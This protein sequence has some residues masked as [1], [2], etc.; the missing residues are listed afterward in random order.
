MRRGIV[1]VVVL[2]LVLC[3]LASGLGG[4]AY[5]LYVPTAEARPLV[6]ISSPRHGER[7][8]VGEPVTVQ[9]LARDEAE[10]V[11][12][13]ELWVDG[14]LLEAQRTAASGGISPFPLL[15]DWQ[16]LSP[17]AHTLI[18][19]AFNTQGAR[20]QGSVNVEAM[21]LPDRDGDEVPDD[22]DA[23]PDEAGLPEAD[24]CPV[25]SEGDRDGDGLLDDADACPDEPGSPL[26]GGC[27]D[28]DGDEV[29]D[30]ED[31]CPDEPG[32]PES[33]GCPTP[34]DLDDDGV[35]DEEDD[36]PQEWGMPEHSGCPD[37]DG[38]GLRDVDD[39]CPDE[40]G[41]L[42]Q[43]GCPD[44]DSDGVPDSDDLRP[45][46]PGRV[47][48]HGA[49]DSGAP[50]S[51]G[52]GL[53]DDIDECD[54]EE[55]L[56]EHAGCPP[57]GDGD[58][59]DDELLRLSPWENLEPFG[60]GFFEPW[61][62]PGVD[63]VII[64]TPVE[65]EALEFEV[66]QDYTEIYCYVGLTGEQPERYG[67]FGRIGPTRWD[68]AEVLGGENSRHFAVRIDEPLELQMECMGYAGGEPPFHLGLLNVEHPRD[69]W[70]GEVFTAWTEGEPGGPPREHRFVVMYRICADSC[71][72]AGLPPPILWPPQGL[73][74]H[75][76]WDWRGVWDSI[77]GFKLYVN[78]SHVGNF[79]RGSPGSLHGYDLPDS[80][81]PACGEWL[82]FEVT[83]FRGNPFDPDQESPPSNTVVLEGQPCP[84]RARVTF[85]D[86]Q[87]LNWP[88]DPPSQH[89]DSCWEEDLG[90]IDLRFVVSHGVDIQ[91]FGISTV[92]GRSPLC[93][94]S[95][96]CNR[97]QGYCLHPYTT[98]S[99]E[100]IV[101]HCRATRDGLSSRRAEQL[102]CPENFVEVTLGPRDELYV[103]ASI[104]DADTDGTWQRVITG[105]LV[106]EPDDLIPGAEYERTL[107]HTIEYVAEVTVRIQVLPVGP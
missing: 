97:I 27:P 1:I 13:V 36:C 96:E 50:D 79:E 92:Y 55:G 17:G 28:A 14:E 91:E 56:A 35:A 43:A 6:L 88:G 59:A 94:R 5:F 102:S 70:D 10:R 90:P 15:T 87:T 53:P 34:E 65:V 21:E 42:E 100:D 8:E 2:V 38:D 82:E 60:G 52:D 68:I 45:D 80:L 63:D 99:I 77:T 25:L 93:T 51:D 29:A 41:V 32:L 95:N 44:R 33:D 4:L 74:N 19:R 106:L 37:R 49:P 54:D 7:V 86:V 83:A 46:E 57:P 105:D 20:A 101:Q 9:A 16:P 31:G 39:D 24:G 85:L 66:F 12:R 61:G 3:C 22:M 23:C 64:V 40:Q 89:D 104:G 76:T 26:S 103:Y 30:G 69:D 67:P 75:L 98:H 48:D 72:E 84:L 11:V 107:L 81:Q 78:G 18:V 62:P 73:A 71:E 47:E 58:D